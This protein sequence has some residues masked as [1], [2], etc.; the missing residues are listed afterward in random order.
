M[1]GKKAN[2][3]VTLDHGGHLL[4]R[5]EFLFLPESGQALIFPQNVTYY[6]VGLWDNLALV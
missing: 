5:W 3:E 6:N 2:S 1:V 4:S